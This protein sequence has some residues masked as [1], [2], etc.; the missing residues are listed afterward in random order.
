MSGPVVFGIPSKGRLKTDSEEFFA[1]IG[2]EF[3]A[4]G[5]SRS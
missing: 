4:A 2:L 1:G 5:G 3:T